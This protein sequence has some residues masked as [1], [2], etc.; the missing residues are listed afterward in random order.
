MYSI[1]PCNEVSDKVKGNLD[2][3]VGV[4]KEEIADAT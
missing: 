2:E 1:D 4:A 3:T